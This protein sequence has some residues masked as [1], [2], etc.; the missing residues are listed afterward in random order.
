MYQLRK[1][2]AVK[3]I[4]CFYLSGFPGQKGLLT[5]IQFQKNLRYTYDSLPF[6]DDFI[7]EDI[8]TYKRNDRA[9]QVFLVFYFS[10]SFLETNCIF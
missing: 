7:H 6:I 2:N 1:E 4:F 10:I 5:S 8:S 9:W 3:T